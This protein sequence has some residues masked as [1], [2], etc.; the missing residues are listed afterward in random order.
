M[1]EADVNNFYH[2]FTETTIALLRHSDYC[3]AG[4]SFVSSK[5]PL[6]NFVRHAMYALYIYSKYVYIVFFFLANKYVYIVI[7]THTHTKFEQKINIY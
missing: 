4:Y 3:I 6:K 7:H 1:I 2:A 5:Y